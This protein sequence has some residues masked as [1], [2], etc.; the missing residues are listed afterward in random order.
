MLTFWGRDMIVLLT[1]YSCRDGND[2]LGLKEPIRELFVCTGDLFSD[3][4]SLFM[5]AFVAYRYGLARI[6]YD[7]FS[8][9]KSKSS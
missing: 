8:L 5:E 3:T 9:W 7:I 1:F 4:P 6:I 2:D